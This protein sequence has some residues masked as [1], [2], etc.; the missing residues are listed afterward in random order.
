[1]ASKKT[2]KIIHWVPR[3]LCILAILFISIFALDAFEPDLTVWQQIGGFMMHLIPSFVLLA[4]CILAWKK[5]LIGGVI[6]T[7][8]GVVLSPFIYNKNY[9]MNHSVSMSLGIIAVI[10]LPFIIVGVLF[11]VSHFLK[12]KTSNNN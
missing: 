2:I 8:I 5:E 7:I 6:F 12:K 3:I 11:I 9:N 10:T 1:M 4:V